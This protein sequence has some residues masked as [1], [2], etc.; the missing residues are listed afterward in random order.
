MYQNL[1]QCES[2]CQTNKKK[3]KINEASEYDYLYGIVTTGEDFSYYYG[4]VLLRK[5][6]KEYYC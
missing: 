6:S 4:Y 1:A 3:Q 2:A 5:L